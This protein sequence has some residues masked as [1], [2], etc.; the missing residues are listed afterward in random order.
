MVY[1]P[2]IS[3]DHCKVLRRIAWGLE[4]PMTKALEGIIADAVKSIESSKICQ[5]CKDKNYCRFCVFSK[6]G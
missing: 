4:I 6:G 5:K 2:K 3:E 1:T